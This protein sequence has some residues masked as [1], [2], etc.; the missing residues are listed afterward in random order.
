MSYDFFTGDEENV[1]KGPE[2]AA[3]NFEL[4]GKLRLDSYL[5]QSRQNRFCEIT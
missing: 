2:P 1:S 3:T 4:S 5:N